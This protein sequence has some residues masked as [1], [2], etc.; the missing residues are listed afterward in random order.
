M[1]QKLKA[2]YGS[3]GCTETISVSTEFL[4]DYVHVVR[5]KDCRYWNEMN[6]GCVRNTLFEAWQ[7]NDFCC[8]GERRSE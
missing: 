7:E 2:K 1:I 6:K 5:C 4:D 3:H 8:Y